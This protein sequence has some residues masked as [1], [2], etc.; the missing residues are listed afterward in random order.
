MVKYI[1]TLVIAFVSLQ[2][3]S[4]GSAQALSITG[5]GDYLDGMASDIKS[6]TN[7]FTM[8][9][10][11]NISDTILIPTEAN[12]LTCISGTGGQH[13]AIGPEW[14]SA[15]INVSATSGSGV[16]VGTNGIA[17]Y[18]HK[19][20]YM[21]A[22]LSYSATLPAGWNHVAVVY[23]S[24]KPYLYLNGVLVDS[25]LT[26]QQTNVFPS[27]YIGGMWYGS[28]TGMMDEVRIWNYARSQ[29]QIRDYM[30]QLVD[31]ASAGLIRYY[32][33][34]DTGTSSVKDTSG[35]QD[36]T[37]VNVSLPSQRVLSG[38]PLGDA[39][40]YVYTGSWTGV[41]LSLG[42]TSNG[43]VML[44][45]VA[46]GP[47]GVH[48]YRVDQAPNTS[49]GISGMGTNHVYWGVF[50]AGGSA[51]TY[52]LVYNYSGYSDALSNE[53]NLKLNQRTDNSSGSWNQLSSSLNT[54][55]NTISNYSISGRS[56][57]MLSNPLIPLPLGILSFEASRINEN[58]EL[59][60]ILAPDIESGSMEI[61][62]ST[63]GVHYLTLASLSVNLPLPSTYHF[64]H[65]N[66][67]EGPRYYRLNLHS[68]NGGSDLATATVSGA[69]VNQLSIGPNPAE[70]MVRVQGWATSESISVSWYSFS[71]ALLYQQTV[72]ASNSTGCFVLN[73]PPQHSGEV[74]V[75]QLQSETRQEHLKL[76]V[77]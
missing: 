65:E 21:P 33:F 68:G 27:A 14:G 11:M 54:G 3:S 26:S 12:C 67:G 73:I 30:T 32:R 35:H 42:S 44:G 69:L 50:V 71:G 28:I 66:A 75:L 17:V 53:S 56:E 43:S 39:S 46:G 37:L 77:R 22:L 57:F 8:E 16:S 41:T 9:F 47:D 29:S 64:L 10:W 18:E 15:G 6:V 5:S 40:A 20:N 25:G 76:L 49:N 63:D 48:L 55:A 23:V 38:A 58:V 72:S 62:T 36:A 51:P 2:C 19:A 7:T 70:G 45:S 34:D 13:Y 24:R 59:S 52:D 31:P 61:E 74:L 1:C 60:W 4:Q